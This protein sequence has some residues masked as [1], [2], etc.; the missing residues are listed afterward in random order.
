MEKVTAVASLLVFWLWS[1]THCPSHHSTKLK[2]SHWYFDQCLYPIKTSSSVCQKHLEHAFFYIIFHSHPFNEM[3]IVSGKSHCCNDIF[4]VVQIT[5]LLAK[6][7]WEEYKLF[8]CRQSQHFIS[9]FL[10][11]FHSNWLSKSYARKQK[12]LFFFWTQCSNEWV[13]LNGIWKAVKCNR[14]VIKW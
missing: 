13:I 10:W 5:S 6:N 3:F 8:L 12:W 2:M 7:S 4:T 14:N 11:N 9:Y 1:T